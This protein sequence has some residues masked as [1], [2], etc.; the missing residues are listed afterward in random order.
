MFEPPLAF[1]KDSLSVGRGVG[2]GISQA[3][4]HARCA[5]APRWALAQRQ[6]P[7]YKSS[8]N[9]DHV[10]APEAPGPFGASWDTPPT[11]QLGN[12]MFKQLDLALSI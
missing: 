6:E 5:C 12:N 2:D 7:K 8:L 10:G 3:R 4:S 11:G 9:S 1:F